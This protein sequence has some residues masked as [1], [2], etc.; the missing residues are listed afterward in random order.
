MHFWDIFSLNTSQ[1]CRDLLKNVTRNMTAWKA[2]FPPASLCM[3]RHVQKS[4]FGVFGKESDIV[5]TCRLFYCKICCT[6]LSFGS[7]GTKIDKY[8]L[9][10]CCLQQLC[11]HT[12]FGFSLETTIA[13][14]YSWESYTVCLSRDV[15]IFLASIWLRVHSK[16]KQLSMQDKL[17]LLDVHSWFCWKT[18]KEEDEIWLTFYYIS[19]G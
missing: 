16:E 4:K 6:S 2:F 8:I 11:C 1:I 9:W 13:F 5:F 15:R 18:S 17:V 12:W 7:P 3:L 10:T 14:K 19:S